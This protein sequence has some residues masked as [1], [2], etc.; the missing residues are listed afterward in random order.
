MQ[1]NKNRY[2][3]PTCSEFAPRLP[4]LTLLGNQSLNLGSQISYSSYPEG[5]RNNLL[6]YLNS[7]G[8]LC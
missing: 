6:R 4:H 2:Q 7:H 3:A 5:H 1:D 8:C